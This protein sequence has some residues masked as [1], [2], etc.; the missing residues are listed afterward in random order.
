MNA[1]NLLLQSLLYHHQ[2]QQEVYI[3]TY[4]DIIKYFYLFVI[5]R[6]IG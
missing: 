1:P 3:H 4:N 6:I 2:Q 5:A